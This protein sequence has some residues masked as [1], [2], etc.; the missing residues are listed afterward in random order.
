M[1]GAEVAVPTDS[2]L[3]KNSTLT[4]VPSASKASAVRAT[5]SGAVK[6]LVENGNVIET[7]GAIL[8]LTEIRTTLD[9]VERP[10][11]SV[12]TA[13]IA[14]SVPNVATHT[15]EYGAVASVPTETP[16]TKNSTSVMIPSESEAVDENVMEEP[17]TAMVGA[18]N[19]T[20]GAE[21]LDT[22]TFTV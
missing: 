9:V 4:I 17:S 11:S 8:P 12:A 19:V 7:V 2:P 3:M 6:S 1:N 21:L 16:S 20:E 15:T 13:V 14:W 22:V 10:E 5:F 18:S